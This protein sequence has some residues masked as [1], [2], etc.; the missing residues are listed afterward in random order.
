MNLVLVKFI[1]YF[2]FKVVKNILKIGNRYTYGAV[3]KKPTYAVECY[4]AEIDT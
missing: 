1:N 4:A 3:S 2:M